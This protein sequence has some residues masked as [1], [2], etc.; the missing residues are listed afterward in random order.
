MA[1]VLGAVALTALPEAALGQ[2]ATNQWFRVVSAGPPGAARTV[3]ANGVITGVGTEVIESNPSGVATVKWTFPDG[4]VSV[5]IDFTFAG[6]LNPTTCL[7]T[8]TLKGTWEITGATGAYAGATGGGDFS[9]TNRI[10]LS[11]TENGCAPP[12]VFLAQVFVFT[13]HVTLGANLA[14]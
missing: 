9:G 13:G 3:I 7:R 4:T 6:D 8:L 1:L 5:R 12:P 11:R 14:A 10:L 2:T